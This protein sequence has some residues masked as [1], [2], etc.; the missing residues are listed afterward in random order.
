MWDQAKI[1]ALPTECDTLLLSFPRSGNSWA[2]YIIE[3]TAGRPTVDVG[4]N[5]YTW[6]LPTHGPAIAYKSHWYEPWM[7]DRFGRLIFLVRNY[8]ECMVRQF[9]PNVQDIL[10]SMSG[11]GSPE[12][13]RLDYL[14][15][16]QSYDAWPKEKM[17][18]Y[19]ESL[20]TNPL[21]E[22]IRMTSFL[23]V[24]GP[25]VAEF[26]NHLDQHQARSVR[27]YSPGSMTGGQ[28][29]SFHAAR[30]TPAER[31]RLD[32]QMQ[33]RRPDLFER[34]LRRYAEQ[35]AAVPCRA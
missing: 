32:G 24:A 29:T 35:E 17:L 26:L 22:I 2:R 10:A 27:C 4:E 20:V 11:D 33:A 13:T 12:G 16:L 31:T 23:G 14:H 8:K 6:D 28:G 25:A 15:L 21:P 30:L 18:V 9:G 7:G 5:P 34:Y 3:A 19:Y 1:T